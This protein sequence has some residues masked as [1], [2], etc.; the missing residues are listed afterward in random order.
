LI[1]FGAALEYKS[2]ENAMEI[3]EPLELTQE[4]EAN[5]KSLVKIALEQN[6][7]F[8]AER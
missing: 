8:V 2:L 7:F 1:A 6:N 3:L 5:W 4:N